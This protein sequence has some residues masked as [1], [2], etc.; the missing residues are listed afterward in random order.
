MPR[1]LTAPG[2]A[3]PCPGSIAM[4]RPLLRPFPFEDV[5][6]RA[7][8][9]KIAPGQSP[10]TAPT[11]NASSPRRLTISPPIPPPPQRPGI[12]TYSARLWRNSVCR[13]LIRDRDALPV[14]PLPALLAGPAQHDAGRRC[15]LA[16][17]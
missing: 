6:R 3:P 7:D 1:G 16:L 11:D 15:G 12:S 8:P 5:P 9:A 10:T 2:S 17:L 4:M 13:E 14:L